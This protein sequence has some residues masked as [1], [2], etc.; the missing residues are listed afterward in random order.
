MPKTNKKF[1]EMEWY[2][3]K[4][5]KKNNNNPPSNWVFLTPHFCGQVDR[6]GSSNLKSRISKGKVATNTKR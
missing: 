4:K 2:I 3:S 5:T 1:E 6:L